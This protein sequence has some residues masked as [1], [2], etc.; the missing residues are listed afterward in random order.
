M[1][2][3][4]R[5]P[6]LDRHGLEVISTEE[7]WT[8]LASTP[9]GRLAFVSDG[10]PVILPVSFVLHGHRIAFRSAKGAKLDAVVMERPL[11]FEVDR[12]DVDDRSGWS[13]LVEGT[14]EIV[15]DESEEAELENIGLVPWAPLDVAAHWVR[16]VPNEITGRRIPAAAGDDA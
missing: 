2:P 1:N 14:A 8:L 6:V 12:W 10:E 5:S 13:V 16:I 11:A 3:T 15:V 9:I 7:C 4:P